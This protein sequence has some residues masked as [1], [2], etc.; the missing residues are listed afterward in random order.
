MYYVLNNGEI[1]GSYHYL[2]DAEKVS[3]GMY[4]IFYSL[5]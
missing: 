4:D 3:K 5:R 2:K 1:I